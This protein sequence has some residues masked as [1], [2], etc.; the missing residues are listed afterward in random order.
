[1]ALFLL[2]EYFRAGGGRFFMGRKKIGYEKAGR[3][4][5]AL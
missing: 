1:V 5:P 4:L 3:E 2:T